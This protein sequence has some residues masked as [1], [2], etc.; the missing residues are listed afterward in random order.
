[1]VLA[2][3]LSSYLLGSIPFAYIFGRVIKG[4]DIRKFGSGN[5]GAT[6]ALR[7]LGPLFGITVLILDILKGMLAVTWLADYFLPYFSGSAVTLRILF[8]I[9]CICGH[10]WTLFLRFKG[11]KGVATTLGAITG[12][13]IMIEGLRVIL[14]LVILVWVLVF[15]IIRL[16]SL[17][18]IISALSFP[19]FVFL[20]RQPKELFLLSVILAAFILIRHKKNIHGI[21]SGR[22][23][24]LNP[25]TRN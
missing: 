9:A 5:V 17:A 16:V 24:P 11:G 19:V 14:L 22:E 2:G 4:T 15:L 3:I 20:F 25:K 21:L 10:N 7:L 18:S 8:A 23:S 1:M 13:A 12:L 6:N